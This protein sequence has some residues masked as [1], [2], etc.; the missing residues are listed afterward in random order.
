MQVMDWRRTGP[1][2]DLI[3]HSIRV[4]ERGT[5]VCMWCHCTERGGMHSPQ[6]HEVCIRKKAMLMIDYDACEACCPRGMMPTWRGDVARPALTEWHEQQA[7]LSLLAPSPGMH[8][9]D[10]VPH[11]LRTGAARD[12]DQNEQA[13]RHGQDAGGGLRGGEPRVRGR[14]HTRARQVEPRR[15]EARGRRGGREGPRVCNVR[16]N[17]SFTRWPFGRRYYVPRVP[18]TK[19]GQSCM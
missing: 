17:C 5:Y 14:P 4:V 19:Q 9:P 6:H 12:H 8:L 1:H 15:A 7:P 11:P 16:G 18:V 2:S 13:L 3:R 10:P